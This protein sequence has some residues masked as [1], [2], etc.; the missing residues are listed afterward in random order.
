MI[1]LKLFGVMLI[2][3][4]TIAAV[5]AYTSAYVSYYRARSLA[6]IMASI[7]VGRTTESQVKILTESFIRKNSDDSRVSN[8]EASGSNHFVFSNRGLALLKLSPPKMVTAEVGYQNG[9]V[10]WKDMSFYEGGAERSIL[11][12]TYQSDAQ[13]LNL[14]RGDRHIFIQGRRPPNGFG[15]SLG[16]DSALPAAILQSDWQMDMSCMAEIGPCKHPEKI[17]PNVEHLI[18]PTAGK[19]ILL[20]DPK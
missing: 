17:L 11:V 20:S 19:D 12:S 10:V 6:R 13:A 15:I 14:P 8:L 3:L 9:L 2:T 4:V 1:K 18:P 16:E 7:E 5:V